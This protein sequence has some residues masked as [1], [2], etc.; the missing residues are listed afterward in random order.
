[1]G[2]NPP[3]A[4]LEETK[5]CKQLSTVCPKEDMQYTHGTHNIDSKGSSFQLVNLSINVRGTVFI[6]Y[7]IC[8]TTTINQLS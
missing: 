2:K 3:F 4:C 7:N 1:M 5:S 6:T 8:N